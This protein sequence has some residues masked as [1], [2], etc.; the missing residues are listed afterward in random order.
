MT[1]RDSLLVEV[2]NVFFG[3]GFAPETGNG[4]FSVEREVASIA[5]SFCVTANTYPLT[6]CKGEGWIIV[7]THDIAGS[8]LYQ[9]AVDIDT[10]EAVVAVKYQYIVV[11]FG[12][13]S[14][15]CC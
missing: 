15:R 14:I 1:W 7:D 2:I 6:R 9:L 12:V 5:D 3:K 10:G 4:D 13:E 8:T 11:V